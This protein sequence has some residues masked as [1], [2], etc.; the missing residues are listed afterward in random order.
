MTIFEAAVLGLVQGLTEFLPVSS[1]GH[2]AVGKLLFGMEGVP[3]LFDVLLHIA[4]LIVVVYVFRRRIGAILAALWRFVARRPRQEPDTEQLRLVVWILLA[5]IVTVI[6]ALPV[7]KLDIGA[8]PRLIGGF[9]LFTAIVLLSTLKAPEG[10][11]FSEMGPLQAVIVG[12][13]QGLGVFPGISRSGITISAARHAG[14]SR[15]DAG[16]FA[17]LISIPAILGALVLTLRDFGDLGQSVGILALTAGFLV[18]LLSGF[19]ALSLL[20]RIVRSGRL[21]LFSIY[22]VPL[23]AAVILLL[24]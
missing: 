7:A 16:E 18:A 22:L 17:F 10:G 23:G 15:G 19:L 6:I 5:T 8:R 9:F 2:L 21:Y 20:L 3:L 12:F 24:G 13:A 1:S 4:T 14:L 11:R